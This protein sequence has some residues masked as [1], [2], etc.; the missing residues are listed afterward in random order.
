MQSNEHQQT[1]FMQ[2]NEILVEIHKFFG[3]RNIFI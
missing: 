3:L 1:Q 2:S